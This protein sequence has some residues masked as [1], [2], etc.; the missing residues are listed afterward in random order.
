MSY[1]IKGV[2]RIP[3]AFFVCL[4]C[5]GIHYGIILNKAFERWY[6]TVEF[7][8]WHF[9]ILNFGDVDDNCE[10]LQDIGAKESVA[11]A[12]ADVISHF[13]IPISQK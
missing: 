13:K 9:E 11:K 10:K 6:C 8:G 5:D 2:V 3:V 7:W 12:I 4:F 1:K